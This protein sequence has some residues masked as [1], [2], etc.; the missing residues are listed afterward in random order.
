[1]SEVLRISHS[2]CR[3]RWR[4]TCIPCRMKSRPEWW[5]EAGTFLHTYRSVLFIQRKMKA[6]QNQIIPTETLKITS[7][8][9]SDFAIFSTEH[10]KIWS[11]SGHPGNVGYLYC[12]YF[13]KHGWFCETRTFNMSSLS[14][15]SAD[16]APKPYTFETSTAVKKHMS[17]SCDLNAWSDWKC[18]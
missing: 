11:S 3:S 12:Y 10:E 15:D 13:D 5:T 7:I 2:L 9:Q 1:M 17:R 6:W 16:H 4:D 14:A 18:I 8:E